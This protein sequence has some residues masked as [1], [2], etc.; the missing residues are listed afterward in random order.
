VVCEAATKQFYVYEHRT[1]SLREWFIRTV[2]RRPR[3]VRHLEFS[4]RG[5]DLRIGRGE[6][7]ALVGGNGSGKSTA[8]R[9]IAGIYTPTRGSVT[10]YGRL[11]AVIELGAGFHQ[12]LTGIENVDLYGAIL[13][14][15]RQDLEAHRKRI[16]DFAG[17]GPFIDMPVKYYSSGMRARLAFS[18]AVCGEPDILLLDEVLAVGDRPFQEKCLGRLHELN[19]AGSTL[20]VVSHDFATL[21]GLCSRAV[22]LDDGGIRMDGPLEAVL[23]AYSS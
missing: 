16:L 5:F 11:A 13:G 22:W 1:A 4:L 15:R 12:E 21:R 2:T 18:V 10:T 20:V 7:V 8:L 14:W 9:M 23:E 19:A 17:I 6:A 3:H